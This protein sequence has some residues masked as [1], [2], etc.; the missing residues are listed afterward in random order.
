MIFVEKILD[1]AQHSVLFDRVKCR[2]DVH[3]DEEQPRPAVLA[4]FRTR[5]LGLQLAMSLGQVGPDPMERSEDLVCAEE[6]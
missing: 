3:L 4:L 1:H 6:G 5:V 2:F